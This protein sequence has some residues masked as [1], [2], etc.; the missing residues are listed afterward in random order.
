MF[1]L[2]RRRGAEGAEARVF[3]QKFSELCELRASVVN[4]SFFLVA[5]LPRCASVVNTPMKT[6]T[7]R[8][9]LGAAKQFVELDDFRIARQFLDRLIIC[10]W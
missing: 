10:L 8:Q 2:T 5:A 3:D 7:R 4:L 6:L 9:R 1:N